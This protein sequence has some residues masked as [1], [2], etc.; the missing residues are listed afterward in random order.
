MS[1]GV[2]GGA[3]NCHECDRNMHPMS[4]RGVFW[5][6]V[7]LM[8]VNTGTGVSSVLR[9]ATESNYPVLRIARSDW[10]DRFLAPM[11]YPARRY[12]QLPALATDQSAETQQAATHLA[13]AWSL[14]RQE[15]YREAVQRCR[16]ANDA[17]LAPNKTTWTQNTLDPVVGSEKAAM[18]DV[19]LRALNKIWND[20]SHGSNSV[21]IDRE[22]AEYV[23]GSMT[24]ILN[25]MSRKLR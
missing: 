15:R 3:K 13:E 10:L 4:W 16:Q 21:E 8:N 19:G 9:V 17:L 24:L 12:V 23:I 2:Q 25:Y 6:T 20:A 11:G 7:F 22:A 5:G 1:D 18:V 14:F